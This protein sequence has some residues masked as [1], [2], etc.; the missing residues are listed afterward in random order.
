VVD[1]D[2]RFLVALARLLDA[3]LAE[4]DVVVG[5]EVRPAAH[6]LEHVQRERREST[7]SACFWSGS[8]CST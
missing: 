2:R 1:A 7:T 6:V 3:V 4:R 8:S 5:D